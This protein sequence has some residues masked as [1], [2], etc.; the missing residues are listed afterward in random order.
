MESKQKPDRVNKT[1]KNDIL[2]AFSRYLS[3]VYMHN[4]DIQLSL[5]FTSV[6]PLNVFC[7]H[8]SRSQFHSFFHCLQLLSSPS[9]LLSQLP[10]LQTST[11]DSRVGGRLVYQNPEGKAFQNTHVC[12]SLACSPPLCAI[13]SGKMSSFFL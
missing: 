9:S 3:L 11:R 8:P 12:H 4:Q 13:G 6:C 5:S 1:S 7:I 2:T 10:F